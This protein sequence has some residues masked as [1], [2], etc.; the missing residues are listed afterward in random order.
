MELNANVIGRQRTIG[1][2]LRPPGHQDI[3]ARNFDVV[4]DNVAP[5]SGLMKGDGPAGLV[6]KPAKTICDYR[7]H[8]L[9]SCP[10]SFMSAAS[11]ARAATA[12]M[13]A[14]KIR[15]ETFAMVFKVIA[16]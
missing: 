16:S 3:G 5:Q 13:A 10:A 8:G 1:C 6:E 4:I 12:G 9:W 2:D 15:L 11:S 7:A 14:A